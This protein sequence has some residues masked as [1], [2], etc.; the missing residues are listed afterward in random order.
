MARHILFVFL[1][2][3]FCVK[4]LKSDDEF[5]NRKTLHVYKDFPTNSRDKRTVV[6]NADENLSDHHRPKRDTEK[7]NK[8]GISKDITVKVCF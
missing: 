4:S 2:L 1:L 7:S 6:F 5:F 3:Y 8:S